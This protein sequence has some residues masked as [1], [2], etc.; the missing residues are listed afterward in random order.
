MRVMATDACL[1]HGS[2]G[3]DRLKGPSCLIV[4]VQVE[5][6]SAAIAL[7]HED[8]SEEFLDDDLVS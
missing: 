5:G 4:A 3:I 7:A 2:V 1:S 6:R 8:V